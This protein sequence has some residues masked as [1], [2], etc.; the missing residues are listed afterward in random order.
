VIPKKQ[1]TTTDPEKVEV[2]DHSLQLAGTNASGV[3]R[4]TAQPISAPPGASKPV[5]QRVKGATA[6][7]DW[8]QPG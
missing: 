7:D 6:K 8:L 2:R 5:N 4:Y 3:K 1:W